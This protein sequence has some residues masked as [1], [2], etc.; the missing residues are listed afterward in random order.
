MLDLSLT[1][2]RFLQPLWQTAFRPGDRVKLTLD[3][4]GKSLY[5]AASMVRVSI[6]HE[7]TVRPP[8][9]FPICLQSARPSYGKPSS[10]IDRK[11]HCRERKI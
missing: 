3:F 8:L 6:C 4:E 5:L 2:L 7:I 11:N 1:G 10:I 9:C